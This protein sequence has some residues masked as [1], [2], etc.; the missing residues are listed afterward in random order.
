[1]PDSAGGPS[2]LVPKSPHCQEPVKQSELD[3]SSLLVIRIGCSKNRPS[4]LVVLVRDVSLPARR[5]S[6]CCKPSSLARAVG[7]DD[8]WEWSRRWS[9][10]NKR[11]VSNCRACRLCSCDL[12]ATSD[13][14][15]RPSRC[16]RLEIRDLLRLGLQYCTLRFTC[17]VCTQFV[18]SR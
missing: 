6:A 17:H 1:M 8:R 14:A 5:S 3:S 11:R 18:R 13:P 9:R 16:G 4:R 12:P 2:S 7:N 15:W 10:S